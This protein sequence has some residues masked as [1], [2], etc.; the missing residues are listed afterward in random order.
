MMTFLPPISRWQCL[1]AGAQ[2]SETLRPT[3]VE[4]VKDTI[5]TSLWCMRGEPTSAPPPVTMF[6]TPLG[7]PAS[8]RAFSEVHHRERG[9]GGRLDHHRVADDQGGHHLPGGD[10]HG[11]VPGRD[12]PGDAHGLAHR[13]LELAGHLRGCGLA[14]LAPAL[15]PPCSTSCRWLPGRRRGSR[16][17]PCPSRGSCRARTPP[18]AAAGSRPPGR[19]SRRAWGRAVPSTSGSASR[20][21]ATA[22]STSSGPESAKMPIS[23]LVSAGLR[24]SKVLPE[25]A[26]IQ[27]P[28]M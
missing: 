23:S 19:G 22:C 20:A 21:A 24:F 3:P 15:R 1:K 28:A 11:E 18:C 4:P 17:G 8:A 7:S 27:D 13:H 14:E 2:A 25:A 6:T 5:P 16:P 26:G 9:V 12:E 10:G